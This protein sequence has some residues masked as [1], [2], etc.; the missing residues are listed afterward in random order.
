MTAKT[1][2]T[3]G[4]ALAEKGEVRAAA[5]LFCQAVK[6]EP[7]FAEGYQRLGEALLSLEHW[8]DAQ[9]CFCKAI[10]LAPDYPEAYNYLGIVLKRR[11]CL[12]EAED[13]YR[14]AIRQK[15]DYAEAFNNLA[16]CLKLTY[17]F[18]EAETAY[19]Q[20]LA[21]QPDL[22]KA[23]FS[24]ATL[25]LLRGRYNE[26]WKLYDSRFDWQKKFRLDIPIWQGEDL[27]ERRILL[28]YEQGYGDMIQAIRYISRVAKLAAKTTVWIQK[29]LER[30]LLECA[31]GAF[32]VCSEG[33]SLKPDQFDF[34]CS[35]FSL[36][37]KF[38]LA[39]ET[40]FKK[41]PYLQPDEKAAA[42][43]RDRL[44]KLAGTKYKVG[45]AW[46]GNPKHTN[47]QNR[48]VPFG[49]FRRLF[50]VAG[51]CWVSLQT[52][53]QK[54]SCA[55]HSD[56]ILDCSGQLVDFAETA[57][58]IDNLDLVI[59]VDTAVAHLAGAMGKKTWLLLPHWPDWRW[60]LEGG[61]TVWYPTMRLFRQK[62]PG[63]WPGVLE[64]VRQ[65]LIREVQK[66][67]SS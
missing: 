19:Q 41:V 49:L 28:F 55:K 42:R 40:I 33:R 12:A 16:N 29:P 22:E 60:G 64:K 23:R 30:L 46:A 11:H 56:A 59:A 38:D 53:E 31:H 45:V 14:R 61:D 52:G 62:N 63:D 48:S 4:L 44:E 34:A 65:S 67:P 39:V 3:K 18:D 17:R 7:A 21:L 25:Y 47:D 50:S 57:G 5:L 27:T 66:A 8:D 13:C 43:W 20:A 58:V 32:S 36:P 1:Y 10:E 2:I 15:P 37:A 51:V 54:G 24:L 6:N 35:L 26:G 9:R